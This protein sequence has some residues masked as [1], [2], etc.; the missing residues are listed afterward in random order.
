MNK[1]DYEKIQRLR[2]ALKATTA[3]LSSI[4][5]HTI[6]GQILFKYFVDIYEIEMAIVNALS[7]IKETQ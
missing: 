2:E 7:A 3:H 5:V 4:V 6:Q 1:T